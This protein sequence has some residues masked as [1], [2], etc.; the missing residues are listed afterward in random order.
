[1]V[2][3]ETEHIGRHALGALPP[4][5]VAHAAVIRTNLHIHH[6]EQFLILRVYPPLSRKHLE[7]GNGLRVRH[8]VQSQDLKNPFDARQR[9]FPFCGRIIHALQVKA[10]QGH[11]TFMATTPI[12]ASCSF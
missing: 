6:I 8:G 10:G 1:M 2:R 7:F 4:A 5:F 12:P 3:Q 9:T 11:T